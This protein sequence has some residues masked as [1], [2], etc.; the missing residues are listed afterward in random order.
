MGRRETKGPERGSPS[1]TLTPQDGVT[2]FIFFPIF[3]GWAGHRGTRPSSPGPVRE[4]DLEATQLKA[5]K[6]VR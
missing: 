3:L 6:A 1:P 5:L 2:P 4:M